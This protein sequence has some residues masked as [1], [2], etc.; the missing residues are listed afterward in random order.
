MDSL[1][2]L[3]PLDPLECRVLLVL[4]GSLV[5]LDQPETREMWECPEFQD[6]LEFLGL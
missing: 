3:V 2:T 1:V 5:Q 4:L 6:N